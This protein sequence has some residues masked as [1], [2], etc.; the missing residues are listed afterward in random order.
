MPNE[1]DRNFRLQRNNVKLI[2]SMA[3][4]EGFSFSVDKPKARPTLDLPHYQ[5]GLGFCID[6]ASVVL[7]RKRSTKR[8]YIASLITPRAFKP[9]GNK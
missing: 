6:T 5:N 7:M 9:N 8:K 1:I 2:V 3:Q 4:F